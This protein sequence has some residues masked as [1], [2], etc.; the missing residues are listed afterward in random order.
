MFDLPDHFNLLLNIYI[1]ELGRPEPY[2]Y[3][4]YLLFSS[5]FLVL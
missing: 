4:I 3:T 1:R 5:R 2:L